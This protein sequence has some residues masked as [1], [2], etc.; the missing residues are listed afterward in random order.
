MQGLRGW[1]RS[2]VARANLASALSGRAGTS[3]M[4]LAFIALGC[5]HPLISPVG[6]CSLSSLLVAVLFALSVVEFAFASWHAFLHRR[7]RVSDLRFAP[8]IVS[9]S[10]RTPIARNP[11]LIHPCVPCWRGCGRLLP[12]S[13]QRRPSAR[14]P[15]PMNLRPRFAAEMLLNFRNVSGLRS[16]IS[17]LRDALSMTPVPRCSNSACS[18]RGAPTPKRDWR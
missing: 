12:F 3:G 6:F 14:G 4:H 7:Y 2:A 1:T 17:S 5:E 15:R 10:S 9:Y 16:A 13:P 8:C 11:F 18:L